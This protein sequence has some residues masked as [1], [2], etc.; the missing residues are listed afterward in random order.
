MVEEKDW[1]RRPDGEE[2]D[3]FITRNYGILENRTGG[4]EVA[5]LQIELVKLAQMRRLEDAIFHLGEIMMSI[6]TDMRQR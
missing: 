4:T 1:T 6:Q 2:I 3:E 5:G